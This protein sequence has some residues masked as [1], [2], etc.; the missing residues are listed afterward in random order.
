MPEQMASSAI[1]EVVGVASLRQA[2]EGVHEEG[3]HQV[4]TCRIGLKR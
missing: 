4:P 2:M 3:V 1:Q